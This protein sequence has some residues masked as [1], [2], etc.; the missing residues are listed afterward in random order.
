MIMNHARWTVPLS[1]SPPSVCFSLWMSVCLCVWAQLSTN[2]TPKA[3]TMLDGF[4]AENY[5]NTL[6]IC[7]CT[8]QCARFVLQ[9]L[10]TICHPSFSVALMEFLCFVMAKIH[11]YWMSE[12]MQ[13]LLYT[14][15]HSA[16]RQYHMPWH[17]IYSQI[18]SR[19]IFILLLLSWVLCDESRAPKKIWK[20]NKHVVKSEE[21][22]GELLN[23]IFKSSWNVQIRSCYL[24]SVTC[25]CSFVSLHDRHLFYIFHFQCDRIWNSNLLKS[26]F[27]LIKSINI[28]N[29]WNTLQH[30][31]S[32]G[33]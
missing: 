32:M 14:R 20:T 18:V 22:R 33:I 23:L 16:H 12:P 28:F 2:V 24:E 4:S 17:H 25:I 15:T 3:S 13:L 19:L 5:R 1:Q 21:W 11:V 9:T 10:S 7:M 26:L 27:M 30:I 8:R 29:E 31:G 6:A